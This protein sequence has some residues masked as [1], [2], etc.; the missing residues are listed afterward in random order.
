M[1][2]LALTMLAVN[3]ARADD[4]H[5][6]RTL[7]A[8][9]DVRS[10]AF[11]AGGEIPRVYTCDGAEQ[12]PPLGWSRVPRDTRSIAIL[13]EDLDTPNGPTMQWLVTGLPPDARSVPADRGLPDNAFAAEHS[14]GEVGWL[15]PCPASGIHHYAFHIYALDVPLSRAMSRADFQSV[16]DRHAIASGLLIGVYRRD[17]RGP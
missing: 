9:I 7:V 12:S 15:G 11:S 4:H 2:T 6:D 1:T 10:P 16:I 13:V 17:S 8:H 14:E 3:S 5:D